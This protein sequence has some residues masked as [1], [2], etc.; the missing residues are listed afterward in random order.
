MYTFGQHLKKI[1][2]ARGITQKEMA[3]K[4]NMSERGYQMYEGDVNKPPF[5]QIN[6]ICN[7]LDIPADVLLLKGVLSKLNLIDKVY[8][9]IMEAIENFSFDGRH[10]NAKNLDYPEQLVAINTL[11]KDIEIDYK[12]NQVKLYWKY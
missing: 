7:I 3:Q 1:R 8:P 6:T 5:E 10:I 11:L 12:T 9:F 4:L 2:K